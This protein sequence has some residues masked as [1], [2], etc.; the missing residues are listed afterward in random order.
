MSEKL[1]VV[2]CWHMHQPAYFDSQSNQYKLPWTYLHGIKDYVDMAAHL[3][4]IPNACAVVNFAPTLLEQ[5]DDY[6]KQIQAFLRDG[7]PILDPLL[8]ALNSAKVFAP[9][10]GQKSHNTDKIEEVDPKY[11]GLANACLIL[12]EQ[13]MRANEEQLIKRFKPYQEL[14]ELVVIIKQNPKILAYLDEQYLIDLLMWY[15]LAWLGETVHRSDNRVKVLIEKGHNFTKTDRL[16]LLEIIG[17]LL[18]GIIPRYKTLA[19]NGQVELS[20]TPYAHPIVPLLLDINSAKEAIPDITLPNETHYPGGKERVHWHIEEGL[21]VF[22]KHFGF[23]P[24]GCWPSEGSVSDATVKLLAEHGVKWVASGGGVLRNSM[25]KSG[26]KHISSHQPYSLPDSQVHCFFR[27]DNLSDLIGF[28][29]SNWHGDDAVANFVHHLEGI[30]NSDN[31]AK[32]ITIILD[33]ENAWEYFPNNA[34]YFLSALYDKLSNH[35][36]LELTTFEKCLTIKPAELPN[37]VA[38]SWVYGTFS[39]WIGDAG[40]NRGWEML[41]EAKHKF[42]QVISTLNSEQ[43]QAATKQLAIC[44]G[45]D[46]CWWFGGENPSEAVRDFDHLYRL[47]LAQLYQLLNVTPPE[48]L[49][50]AFTHG[51][52]NPDSGGVM[53]RG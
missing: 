41:I 48:Y 34:Y 2:L 38:G 4:A 47:H 37:L 14:S 1:K 23:I 39:T 44:E 6:V 26:L 27:D 11:Q 21:K 31:S 50:H 7:K 3:E 36:S 51:G 5:I 52:G 28:E 53:R 42:D 17:E 46:W 12:I 18:G 45:S 25:Q 35:H 19:E 9:F 13:C 10:L 29:Y 15:H 40:K 32:V 43:Q 33:G 30:A 24:Q 20:F 22:E 8:A 16:Q 49:N